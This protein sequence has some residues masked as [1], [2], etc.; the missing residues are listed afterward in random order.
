M[1]NTTRGQDEE[2]RVTCVDSDLVSF[3]TGSAAVMPIMTIMTIIRAKPHE[4]ARSL[5]RKM[6]Q[7]LL[8]PTQAATIRSALWQWPA[9]Q[10]A[11]RHASSSRRLTPRTLA[12]AGSSRHAGGCQGLIN[13]SRG[14][15]FL[16]GKSW[17]EVP[18]VQESRLSIIIEP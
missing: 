3:S 7:R 9:A 11:S 4:G 16:Q 12:M 13:G 14:P 5:R 1:H 17:Q 8:A 10:G 15:G 6:R 2:R 18:L